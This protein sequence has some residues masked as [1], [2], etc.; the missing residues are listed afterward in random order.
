MWWMASTIRYSSIYI[1]YI[2]HTSFIHIY[3]ILWHEGSAI[4]M[5]FG[6]GHLLYCIHV[7]SS[8]SFLRLRWSQSTPPHCPPLPR[9]PPMMDAMVN[10]DSQ[11]A[12]FILHGCAAMDSCLCPCVRPS[13]HNQRYFPAHYPSSNFLLGHR[14][15]MC[16]QRSRLH[17][18]GQYS[19][20]RGG[21]LVHWIGD[22]APREEEKETVGIERRRVVGRQAKAKSNNL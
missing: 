22:E 14:T 10:I 8:R 7:D 16:M 6:N 15:D 20:S 4:N 11:A 17:I 21:C 5:R 3:R 18:D 13:V 19:N 1:L 2:I 12:L 9:L